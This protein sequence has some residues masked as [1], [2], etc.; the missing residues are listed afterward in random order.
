MA[1]I[2]DFKNLT[3]IEKLKEQAYKAA[4]DLEQKLGC[5][6]IV[7]TSDTGVDIIFDIDEFLR[8]LIRKVKEHV[9]RRVLEQL[10]IRATRVDRYV[11]IKFTRR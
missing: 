10:D 3:E 4:A 7:M 11:A 1:G 6:V 5:R 2:K 8:A 9:D